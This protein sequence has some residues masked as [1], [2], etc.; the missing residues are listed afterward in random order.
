LEGGKKKKKKKKPVSPYCYVNVISSHTA[1]P[2]LINEDIQAEPCTKYIQT[3]NLV[4]ATTCI[5]F[6]FYLV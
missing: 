6:F 4:T 2:F 3:E 5:S 1:W